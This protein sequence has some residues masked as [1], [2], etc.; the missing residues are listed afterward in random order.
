MTNFFTYFIMIVLQSSAFPGV[1]SRDAAPDDIYLAAR[2]GFYDLC[3]ALL[4]RGCDF[5]SMAVHRSSPLHAASYYAHDLVVGLL[6]EYGAFSQEN[7]Y[8]NT[9]EAEAGTAV[10]KTIASYKS[11]N[12]GALVG[13]LLAAGLATGEGVRL[14]HHGDEV[15]NVLDFEQFS[16]Y[17]YCGLILRIL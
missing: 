9:P 17:E 12:V 14:L 15:G 5:N 1:A 6:L 13:S 11:D 16:F 2:S 10:R 8:G 3:K 4:E 7:L